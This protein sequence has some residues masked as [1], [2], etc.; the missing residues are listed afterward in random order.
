[1]ENDDEIRHRRRPRIALYAVAGF[2]PIVLA[3]AVFFFVVQR[4]G[5]NNY[6][7]MIE[8]IT[9]HFNFFQMC[10]YIWMTDTFVLPLSP[11]FVFPMVIQF[12]WYFAI[13]A[14]GLASALGGVT[15]YF[16]GRLLAKVPLVNRG[17]VKAHDKWGATIEKY[18]VVFVLIASILPLPFSAVCMAAGVMKLDLV[19]VSLCCT[20]RILRMALYYFLFV[21]GLV[22]V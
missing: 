19:K 7:A 21:L 16:I 17:A 1:M 4:L 12:P 8:Y 3:F 6:Q 11:M 5:R 9:S 22:A 14:T 18:G 15:A 20:T 2:V 10:L 13:P